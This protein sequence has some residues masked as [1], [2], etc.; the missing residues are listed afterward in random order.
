MSEI[1]IRPSSKLTGL[2]FGIAGVVA[3]AILA[4]GLR[5]SHPFSYWYVLFGIPGGIILWAF[6]KQAGRAFTKI[7]ISG[8]KL[9]YES[10]VA[11][12]STRNIPMSKV[13][14]VRVD[15]S[16]MQQVMGI[17]NLS[18]ETAGESSRITIEGIDDPQVVAEKIL[19]LA[20]Q[21]QSKK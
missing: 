17:G 10:G 21:Y 19:E 4:Y 7:T 16:V 2:S 12:K 5:A 1:V 6:A 3:V 18:I 15:R 9:K 13:Q 11:A 20:S 14:D 8:D